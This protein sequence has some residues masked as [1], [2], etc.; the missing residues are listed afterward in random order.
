MI[1]N[2]DD[3]AKSG[4]RVY[5]DIMILKK[6]EKPQINNLNSCLKQLEK[7]Q[8]KPQIRRRKEI[9]KTRAEIN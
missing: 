8:T 6:Q 1:Q 5:S 3:T 4:L 2:P 7:E 9:I